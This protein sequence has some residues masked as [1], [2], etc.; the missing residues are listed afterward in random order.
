MERSANPH[1]KRMR[2]TK[3]LALTF[4]DTLLSSQ[5]T[6]AHHHSKPSGSSFRGNCSSLT[7]PS[8]GRKSATLSATRTRSTILQEVSHSDF[9]A[10]SVQPRFPSP[11]CEARR[12]VGV[13][14]ALTWNKLR[15]FAP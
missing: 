12:R 15:G 2:G 5:R 1:P 3:K 6:R 8:L 7:E 13:R 9:Q 14:V 10:L 4:I 11:S